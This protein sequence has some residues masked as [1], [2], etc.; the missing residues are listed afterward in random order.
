MKIHSYVALAVG[1]ALVAQAQGRERVQPGFD[2]QKSAALAGIPVR[3]LALN[4]RLRVQLAYGYTPISAN[5]TGPGLSS[6]Q[7]A[8]LGAA[9]SLIGGAIVNAAI[10]EGAENQVEPGYAVLQAAQ[11]ALPGPEAFAQ[12]VEN[13]VH[14]TAWGATSPGERRVLAK[15]RQLDAASAGDAPRYVFAVSYS[16][17]PDFGALLTTIDAMAYA[18]GLGGEDQRGMKDPAWVDHLVVASDLM[19]LPARTEA[20][21]ARDVAAENARYNAVVG[22][23]I[24]KANKGDRS[25]RDEVAY[26]KRVH[27]ANT[28]LASLP[29]RL[30]PVEAKERAVA[31]TQDGC[32]RLRGAMQANALETTRVL[33][34][35]FAGRLVDLPAQTL[36]SGKRGFT[37]VQMVQTNMLVGEALVGDRRLFATDDRYVI[38]R[39]AGDAVM[40]GWQYTWYRE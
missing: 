14:A 30:P 13:A 8:G 34:E 2:V 1:L 40:L 29:G 9:G 12:A 27:R 32:A 26:Q 28:S 10:K 23:L 31:W 3:I 15:P 33:G 25:A 24:D 35:L 5:V 6:M 21:I 37:T 18:P 39:R 11:C 22:P 16:L 20:D 19:E 36:V 7:A 17:T 4:D 38:S